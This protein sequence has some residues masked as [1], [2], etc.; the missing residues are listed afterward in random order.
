MS[1]TLKLVVIAAVAE[2]ILVALGVGAWRWNMVGDL[3]ALTTD[4][5]GRWWTGTLLMFFFPIWVTLGCWLAA[6]KMNRPGL[7]M[8]ADTRR[9]SDIT[10]L[11]AVALAIGVQAWLAGGMLGII[12]KNAA[13]VR[14][15]EALAGVFMMVAANFAAKNSPPKGALAPPA[16]AWT[17][18]MMR[19]GW[20]GVA[21]GLVVVVAAITV[22]IDRMVWIIIAA[23]LANAGIA[24]WQVRAMYRQP[25]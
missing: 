12:P 3:A 11:S 7:E 6:R 15:V 8:A 16:A 9:H 10:W 24:F 13:G 14:L 17:R 2:M 25:A 19:I 21:A 22:A 4:Q 20:A 18:G 5:R 23:T 1:R